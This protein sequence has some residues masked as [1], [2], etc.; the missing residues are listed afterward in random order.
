M[1]NIGGDGRDR[2][3]TDSAHLELCQLPWLPEILG[4]FKQSL[5]WSLNLNKLDVS[6]NLKVVD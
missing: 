1:I 2:K 5:Q 6:M 3:L 4:H